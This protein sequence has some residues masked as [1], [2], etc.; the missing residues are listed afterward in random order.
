MIR[1]MISLVLNRT[2]LRQ[3]QGGHGVE[4]QIPYC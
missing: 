1:L 4:N 2:L 3:Y